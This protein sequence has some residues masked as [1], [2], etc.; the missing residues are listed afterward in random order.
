MPTIKDVAEKA[1][2]SI[3]T[4][5]RVF[6]NRG[7][8]SDAVKQKVAG[9]MEALDYHPNELARSLQKRKSWLIGLIV[10]SVAHPFFGEVARY[11]EEAACEKGYKVLLCNSLRESEKEREYI[12]MLKRS[13]VDGII[14]GSHSLDTADYPGLRLPVVSLDRELSPAVPYVCCDNW[15][16][17]E[18]AARLLI[19]KGCRELVHISGSLAVPMLSNRRTDAFVAACTEAGVALHCYEL[20][21]EAI[22]DFDVEAEIRRIL[23]SHPH[24]DGV[25]ATSDLT[26]AAVMGIAAKTGKK[27]P[28]DIKV[29]GFDRVL[30]GRFLN[31]PLTTIRQPVKE[32]SRYAVEFLVRMMNGE[33]VPSKTILPVE[34]L[35][36][37]SA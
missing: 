18:L 20:P 12:K 9:A 36:R 29:I 15:Q 22:V 17:G 5:S 10:P 13:Q 26:A 32:I 6:N 24:C 21:D 37:E 3:A 7:Y 1:G 8:L 31:P 19:G 27:I 14:M 16:G 11:V 23:A 33:Q 30:T 4:V 2:V 34:L 25:F 28:E 35:E